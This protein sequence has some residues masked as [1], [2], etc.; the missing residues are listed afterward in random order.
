MPPIVKV[1]HGLNREENGEVNQ[2]SI[3]AR[4][5]SQAEVSGAIDH[6]FQYMVDGVLVDARPSSNLLSHR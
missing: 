3:V 6:L 5:K 2:S 4:L 1:V